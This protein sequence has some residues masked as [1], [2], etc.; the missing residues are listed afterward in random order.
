VAIYRGFFYADLVE[1]LRGSKYLMLAILAGYALMGSQ[2]INNNKALNRS[3]FF[4]T[5]LARIA[6]GVAM[7]LLRH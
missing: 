5:H 6:V 3:P 2:L 7:D 4:L 1:L